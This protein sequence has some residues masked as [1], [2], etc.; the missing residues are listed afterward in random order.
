[1]DPDE[2]EYSWDDLDYIDWDE[3]EELG[4]LDNDNE[5]YE[6]PWEWVSV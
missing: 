1:M 6:E 2:E 4:W 5:W 3:A